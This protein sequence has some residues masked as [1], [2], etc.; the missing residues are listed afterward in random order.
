MTSPMTPKF[1]NKNRF[2]NAQPQTINSLPEG[3]AVVVVEGYDANIGTDTTEVVVLREGSIMAELRVCDWPDFNMERTF[4][5]R[6]VPVSEIK[7]VI[8]MIPQCAD[9][10]LI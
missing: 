8:R 6:A 10:E 5:N 7:K 9:M 2:K 3:W 4:A 1:L